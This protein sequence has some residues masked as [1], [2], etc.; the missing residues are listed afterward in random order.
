MVGAINTYHDCVWGSFFRRYHS[1]LNHETLRCYVLDMQD[2]LLPPP[3]ED[4]GS[5]EDYQTEERALAMA[6]HN[7]RDY[8]HS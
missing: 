2:G 3:I 4:K 7:P 6:I 5:L 8:T 1:L